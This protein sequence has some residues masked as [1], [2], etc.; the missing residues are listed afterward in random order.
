M[1]GTRMGNLFKKSIAFT[2]IHFGNK[3]NGLDH[4]KDCTDFVKWVIKKGKEE[5]CE[6][7]LFLGDW[8]HQRAS[9][10]IV[11]LNHSVEALTELSKNFD[12]VI[13]LP[14]NHDEYYRD[15]RDVNSISWAKHIPN[16]RIFND[17]TIE[18]DVAI[19]PW[20]VG[21]EYKKIKK[22]EAKYMLGHFELPNFYMNAMVKMPDNGE[23][24]HTDFQGVERMFTGHF[25]KRQEK[26]NISYIGNAFPH[27]FSDVD[28]DERG[29]M[30]LE[31]GEPHRYIYWEDSPKYKSAN[32]SELIK[33]PDKYLLP[34]TYM[35]IYKDLDLSYEESEQL[36]DGFGEKYNIRDLSFI[37]PKSLD[38]DN[39]DTVAELNFEGVDNIVLNQL[40]SVEE[41]SFDPKLLMEIYRDL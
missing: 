40:E 36:K 41:G 15:R 24:K 25:H 30:I 10:N 38:G 35:K 6:T 9:I 26:G 12:Q 7:C 23:I 32:L 18:G 20:L 31:W 5:N 21:Y 3:S 39:E 37:A 28:D 22:I 27:N 8:H 4:N 33:D 16:V 17:I 14:G 29:A 13:F 1:K 34:K 19:V 2:D 11:T